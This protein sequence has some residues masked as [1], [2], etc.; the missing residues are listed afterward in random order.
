M[1]KRMCI[2]QA[3]CYDIGR[4][5]QKLAVLANKDIFAALHRENIYIVYISINTSSARRTTRYVLCKSN[6]II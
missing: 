4:E 3:P 2:L 1:Y 6:N 5:I